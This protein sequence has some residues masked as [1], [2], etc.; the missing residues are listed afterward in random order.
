[1]IPYKIDTGSNGNIM[2]MHIFKNL[3]PGLTN[4][5]LAANIN[6]FI[7]LKMYNKIIMQLGMCKVVA[8]HKN[9]KKNVNFCSSW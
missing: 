6:K 9:N 4:E 3:F 5:Q 7:L 1:M 2:P 8:E